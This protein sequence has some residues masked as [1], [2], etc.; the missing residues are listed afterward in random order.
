MDP[1]STS[2]ASSVAGA[3][4]S[5]NAQARESKRAESPS[6]RF[7]QLLDNVELTVEE[8]EQADA[9][10]SAKGNADEESHEDRQEHGHYDAQGL[11]RPTDPGTLDLNG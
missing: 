1:I 9:V 7:R 10:R 3:K 11:M 8:T 4:Q 6:K 5:E 2:I